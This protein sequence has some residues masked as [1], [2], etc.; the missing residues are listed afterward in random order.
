MCGGNKSVALMTKTNTIQMRFG[1]QGPPRIG[2]LNDLL[3]KVERETIVPRPAG[4]VTRS[5]GGVVFIAD[6]VHRV[7][8]C[9]Y[10]PNQDMLD[11]TDT[12]VPHLLSVALEDNT[13][14]DVWPDSHRI[15]REGPPVKAIKTIKAV[16][17]C[18]N[19]G[20][21]LLYRGDL[22]HA[23][24]SSHVHV[25]L[26]SPLVKRFAN[27]AW[28]IS[29]HADTAVVSAIDTTSEPCDCAGSG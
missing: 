24:K 13:I 8:H 5:V 15:V 19:K 21:A 12:T 28:I 20:D 27:R 25:Y 7:P 9:D 11:S 6:S 4:A 1:I 23:N 26:D 29:Q 16:H 18:L 22:V 3:T 14:M 17:I 10:T 2:W